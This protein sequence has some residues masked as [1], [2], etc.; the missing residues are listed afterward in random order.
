M[1]TQIPSIELTTGVTSPVAI[2]QVGFGTWQVEAD[3]AQGVVENA[4]EVGYRHIDTAAGYYNEAEVGA[5][6]RASG[7]PREELFVT[8]KLR[9]GDQ[10]F[11]QAL[12]AFEASRARLGVDVVDLY[13][14]H[15][16]VPSKDR[17]LETWRAFEKLLA[18]GAVRA[19]GVSNFLAPHLE[20]LV[21]GSTVV[22]AINQVE[23]H[24]TFQ[25]PGTLAAAREHGVAIE[26]YSPLGQGKDV[27]HPVVTAIAERLGVST[28]Q[29]I[30]RWHVQHGHVVIP[31]SVTPE[32][33]AGNLD[34]FSFELSLEDVA[35]IDALDSG[36]RL[37]PDPATASFTQFQH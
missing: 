19:I 20:R 10:G 24:P 29:V 21:A 23:L 36:D 33:I 4:L 7:L 35:A 1:T 27:N 15:L 3:V 28:G 8:T 17:Y 25:Q 13:L 6:L 32:R 34:L 22:P 37:G 12:T 5:A 26:A 16:P 31:K 2:P 18:D 30:L 11:E 14:I 9:N